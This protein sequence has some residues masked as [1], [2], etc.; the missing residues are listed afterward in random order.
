MDAKAAGYAPGMNQNSMRPD[1]SFAA[2]DDSLLRRPDD[3]AVEDADVADD[4]EVDQR[5]VPE[6][7]AHDGRKRENRM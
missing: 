3:D 7:P 5:A 1:G 6:T 4:P 2:E